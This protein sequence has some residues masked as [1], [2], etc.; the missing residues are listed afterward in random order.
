MRNIEEGD[1]SFY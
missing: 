1:D